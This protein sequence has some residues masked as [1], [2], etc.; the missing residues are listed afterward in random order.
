MQ[1]VP[2]KYAMHSC[3]TSHSPDSGSR[4]CEFC[5]AAKRQMSKWM[6]LMG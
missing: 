3:T 4:S 2:I 6:T 5:N 1:S